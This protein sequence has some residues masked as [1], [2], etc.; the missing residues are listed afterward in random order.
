MKLSYNNQNVATNLIASPVKSLSASIIYLKNIGKELLNAPN[1]NRAI[2]LCT[3]E[4]V[5]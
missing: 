5:M 1:D 2:V 4:V 3:D